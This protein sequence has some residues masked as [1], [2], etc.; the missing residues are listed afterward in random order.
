MADRVALVTGATNGVGRVVAAR[1]GAQGWHVL[2]H[3]RDRS[4]GEQVVSEIQARGGS[5]RFHEADLASMSA[6]RQLAEEVMQ[7]H[8]S[9]HLLINNAG[10]GFGRPH[11]GREQ[12][13]D[14]LELRFAVNYL[15]PF[16]LT[17]RL[18]PALLAGAPSRVVNVASIG[19]QE[20]DF[21]DLQMTRGYSGVDAYRRSK[22]ALIMF[23]FDLAAELQKLDVTVNALHPATFMDTFMV[24]E[25][26][27]QPM[28]TV[29]E[30]ADAIMHLA[31][32]DLQGRT[33][34]YF[35]QQRP[36]RAL[37]Q[38]YDLQARGRL[39]Q[40]ANELTAR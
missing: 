34:D 40:R 33:G 39:R 16:L 11:A 4:R 30:G 8:P 2:V 36:A 32:D 27:G 26:G 7:D 1:L 14:G 23:T 12:S 19:Q 24:H 6:V 35:D 31:V 5:A 20:L 37:R 21:D 38:A 10:I 28:S 13:D 18:L 29:D 22:L 9:L 15:A 25:A 3:G 17:H